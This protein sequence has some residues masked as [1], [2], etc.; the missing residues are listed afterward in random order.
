M[1]AFTNS[2]AYCIPR[3]SIRQEFFTKKTQEGT[4]LPKYGQDN[5]NKIRNEAVPKCDKLTHL[6]ARPSARRYVMQTGIPPPG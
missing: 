4:T 3:V 2:F 1:R 6:L 5:H